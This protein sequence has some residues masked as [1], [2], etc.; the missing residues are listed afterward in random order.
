MAQQAKTH[1]KMPKKQRRSVTV[2][3]FLDACNARGLGLEVVVG[4]G[5]EKGL[6][7]VVVEE[8]LLNRPGLIL[9]GFRRYFAAKR[10]Q[11]IGHAEYAY[12]RALKKLRMQRVR[13]LFKEDIPCI[14]VTSN[15]PVLE[16][17]REMAEECGIPVLRT[18]MVTLE[19]VREAGFLLEELA[20]PACNLHG[21]MLEVCGLGTF[22]EGPAGIGKSET[23][24]GLIKR[25]HA[26]VA[27]DFTHFRRM[28]NATLM[29]SARG[30]TRGFMEIRGIGFINVA[31]AFGIGSVRGEKQ[32]DLVI[33]L[34]RLDELDEI[35]RLGTEMECE[36][37]GVSVKHLLLPVAVGRD[38]VNL[39]ETA[40]QEYILRASGY[41]AADDL[42]VQIKQKHSEG[43]K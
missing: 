2:Q 3:R 29:A 10:I 20:A 31:K 41:C 35:D 5:G 25:G 43:D 40:A 16:E 36:M 8:A 4:A 13:G 11:V 42:D 33:T 27:D 37:M 1:N 38:L 12:L 28:G 32:L 30:Q 21:T 39:V 34:K 19:F 6:D 18:E 22:I 9:T 23:A 14:V 26:L 24:L 15:L 17:I 7:G